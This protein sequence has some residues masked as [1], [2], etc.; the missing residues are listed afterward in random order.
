MPR[1]GTLG[2]TKLIFMTL[3]SIRDMFAG[4]WTQDRLL[5]DLEHPQGARNMTSPAFTGICR[6]N[7]ICYKFLMLEYMFIIQIRGLR[8]DSFIVS[9]MERP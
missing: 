8:D 9:C 6:R 5:R 2:S 4:G 1:A 7:L 3:T